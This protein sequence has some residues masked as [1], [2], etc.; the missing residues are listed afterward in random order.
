MWLFLTVLWVGLQFVIVIFP[1][2][3]HLLFAATTFYQ[4]QKDF[5]SRRQS[6]H[7]MNIVITVPLPSTIVRHWYVMIRVRCGFANDVL[8]LRTFNIF[9]K[10]SS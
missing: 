7:N 1:D 9:E 10:R 4:L 3:T 2:H 6:R 5:G 8:L